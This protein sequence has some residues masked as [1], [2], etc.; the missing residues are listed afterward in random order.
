MYSYRYLLNFVFHAYVYTHIV[1]WNVSCT[2][3]SPEPAAKVTVVL[4]EV[5]TIGSLAINDEYE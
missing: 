2:I 4:R 1:T 5:A 3:G